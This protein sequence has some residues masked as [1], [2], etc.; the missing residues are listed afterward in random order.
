MRRI[1]FETAK[2]TI[3][4]RRRSGALLLFS[5]TQ[6]PQVHLTAR[7]RWLSLLRGC[8]TVAAAALIAACGGGSDTPANDLAP[9]TTATLSIGAFTPSVGPEGTVVTVTGTGF[10]G[11]TAAKIGSTAAP[12][13][14]DSATQLRVTVPSGAQTGRIEVSG[15]GRAALSATD[16]TVTG[17]PIVTSVTPTTVP[18]GGRLTV[19]GANLERVASARINATALT[20]A[21]Q[22]TT[23]LAL[24]VP[25]GTSSGFLTLVDSTGTAR[26][27]TQQIT[28]VAPL[29]ITSLTPTTIARG[30]TLTINGSGLSRAQSVRFGGN[31]TAAP[32][33]RTN[34]SLTVAVPSGAASGAVT[35]FGDAGDSVTSTA[36]LT[37]IAPI[38]VD[39]DAVY[40]VA[41]GAPVTITGSGLADVTS[42]T[43]A[44]GSATVVSKSDTQLVFNVP[45][46]INC[47]AIVLAS[48]AQPSVPAGSV[49]VG[50]G[51]TLRSAGVEFAQVLSQP[52]S[53]SYHRLV[54]R[55]ET[56]LRVYVVAETSGV[57]SPS[58][59]AT[60]YNGTTALGTVAASGPATLPVL[61]AG[62]SVP[63]SLRYNEAQS[64]NAE[65][66]A[67]WLGAGLR[68]EIEIDGEQRYGSPLTVSATPAVG[69][70]TRVDL[71]LVPLVSGGN[72]PT[73]PAL[74]DVLDELTRRLPVPRE[75]ITVALR[76]PYTL[77]S[78][79]NGVDTS[80]EWSAALSEL[81]QL[82]DREAP[83]KQYY[84]MVRPM[85]SAGTAGIGYV[86][87][88]GSRS[89][90]LSALG[91]D[92]SRTS[93]RRTMSHELG[94][95][96]SRYH[97]PCGGVADPDPNYPYSG[98]ALSATPLFD[99]LANDV[100]S[101]SGQADVM[102]YCSGSWFS[103]YNLRYVQS[104]LEARPQ[105]AAHAAVEAATADDEVL[106]VAGSINADGLQL[107]PLQRA[108]GLPATA[109]GGAYR[110]QLETSAG[111]TIDVAFDAVEVDH[112]EPAERH[113]F[114]R[115]PAPAGG[116]VVRVDVRH[117]DRALPLRAGSPV[118][119]LSAPRAAVEVAPGVAWR[120]SGGVLE[121]T[122]SGAAYLT[123]THV[124]GATRTVLALDRVGGEARIDLPPLAAGGEFEFSL[125]DG[126]D[127]QL[128]RAAR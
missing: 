58:V 74:A 19:S 30:Q 48:A 94:H 82:R 80:S 86:N 89:P 45:S 87:S 26:Q 110:L 92:A 55:K 2:P 95:N 76:A 61:A 44:A 59:R 127:A 9:S 109:A 39:A 10:D 6:I 119:A 78:V 71:V 3:D 111:A 25:N 17:V 105:A 75:S 113:F 128:V 34:A 43:V 38:V 72:T 106:V 41:A 83:D 21:A 68:V 70:D 90:A 11:V 5:P 73:M 123:V 108:R 65:L 20:I 122:W 117:G 56:W 27:T 50:S 60:G 12:V 18:I 8:A 126:L 54:P 22:S 115:V 33:T 99:S 112:A 53:D 116:R 125:S 104:F 28:I 102:G 84:G 100:L 103:D 4:A 64:F 67:A 31:A 15:N 40:R 35:V 88:I 1:D 7:L 57:A 14:V 13:T 32:A 51:C 24:D 107:R 36:T 47:G 98:G 52:T 49:I 118:R 121:V 66:P 96:Y 85:V 29:A 16:F 101:P 81:E 42:V 77:T 97:A 120:E 23:T 69:T 93:W 114:V 37:V 91:W 79:T 63:A 62:A 46:G 124:L